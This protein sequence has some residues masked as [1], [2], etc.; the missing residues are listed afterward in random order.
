MPDINCAGC[1]L[2]DTIRRGAL[3]KGVGGIGTQQEQTLPHPES[4][5][6]RCS[7]LAEVN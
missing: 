2:L 1:K 5:A 3:H 4:E 7:V 6:Q